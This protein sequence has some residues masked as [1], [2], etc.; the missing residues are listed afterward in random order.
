MDRFPTKMRVSKY[1]QQISLSCEFYGG[2]ESREHLFFLCPYSTQVWRYVYVSL[3][4]TKSAKLFWIQLMD[5]ALSALKRN[6]AINLVMKLRLSA[7][8]YHIWL[9]KNSRMHNGL[10]SS[11][12]AL[13]QKILQNIRDRVVGVPRLKKRFSS[14]SFVLHC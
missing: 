3:G 6:I 7:T 8:I 1:A 14:A 10:P 5:W 2:D 12:M 11:A 4:K 13:A 9:E